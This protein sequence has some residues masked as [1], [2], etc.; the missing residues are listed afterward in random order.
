MGNELRTPPNDLEAEQSVLGAMMLSKEAIDVVAGVVHEEDFYREANRKVYRAIVDLHEQGTPI[1]SITL[2]NELKKRGEFDSIG[3]ISALTALV[4]RVPTAAN[5]E[6][7]AEI[8]Q[9]KATLRRVIHAGTQAV[10]MAYEEDGETQEIVEQAEHIFFQATEKGRPNAYSDMKQALADGYEYL[11]TVNQNKVSVDGIAT[12]FPDL[13]ELLGGL[14]ESEVIVIGARP[15]VGKTGLALNM[16]KNMSWGTNQLKKKYRVG[17]FSL[18]MTRKQLALR[19]LSSAARIDIMKARGGFLNDADQGRIIAATNQGYEACFLINDSSSLSVLELKAQARKMKREGK[20]D[21][22][23]VDYLQLVR[24]GIRCQNR[25]QEVAYVSMQLKALAKDLKIPVVVLAQLSRPMKG[26]EAK[27]PN[28]SDLRESGAIEQDADVVVFIHRTEEERDGR[29]V[30]EHELVL[31]KS[32][33]GP[34]DLID[35]VFRKEY[36]TFEPMSKVSRSA[37]EPVHQREHRTW[38]ND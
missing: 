25:E 36:V 16:A 26:T 11:T 3:G 30:H 33:N 28:L 27:R 13:D 23:F 31:A 2:T 8:V 32:R 17:F 12:G 21:V 5:A 20:I 4:E 29:I 34:T 15:S 9:Q 35:V 22:V 10:A 7:Y 1:D 38:W 14:H 37:E 19:L 18:E 6:H 24:P